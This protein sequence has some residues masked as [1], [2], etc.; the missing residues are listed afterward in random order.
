MTN[1]TYYLLS[2]SRNFESFAKIIFL[3]FFSILDE[4]MD[5]DP[6]EDFVK[7]GK[8]H[9][10][11]LEYLDLR[12][13]GIERIDHAILLAPKVKTLLLGGN[14]IRKI[15]NLSDLPE[16]GV[17]E[18]SDNAIEAIDD[19]N[20]KVGQL[21]RLDLANNKIKTLHGCT[22]LYALQHL[23]G[24]YVLLHICTRIYKNHL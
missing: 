2:T 20:T 22:K 21:T 9:F 5:Q 3:F 18:L 13:N 10:N 19:L 4:S 16:L 12:G 8:H 14:N 1:I 23:N 17:I 7:A 24:N 6:S 15:E 11:N